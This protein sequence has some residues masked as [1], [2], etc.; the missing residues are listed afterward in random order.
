LTVAYLELDDILAI[1]SVVLGL[2]TDALIR[3]TD[4]GLA[5]SAVSRPHASFD[6]QEFYPTVAEKAATLLFGIARNHAFV[7]GNKRV[8]VLATLQFLN[9]NNHD[10]DLQPP[11]EAYKTISG[12]A[13]G[14]I[15]L[16]EL[17]AWIAT[18]IEDFDDS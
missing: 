15:S 18:R 9:L 4:L 11:E 8:A 10:L 2:D 17:T 13:A 5:D 12:V 6:G 7:D 1:A 14:T 3:V 16:D